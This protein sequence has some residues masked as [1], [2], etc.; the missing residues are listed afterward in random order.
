[1]IGLL[2]FQQ[3]AKLSGNAYTGASAGM[4]YW[5]L[6]NDSGNLN[7]NIGSQI[8]LFKMILYSIINL[9]SWQN[10][11]QSLISVSRLILESSEVK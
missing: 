9:A 2:Y 6:N 3:V 8:S 1:V 10:T 4:F 7:Q 5:N 11:K